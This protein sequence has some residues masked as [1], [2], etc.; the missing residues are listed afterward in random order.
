M[1]YSFLDISFKFQL[2]LIKYNIKR[3]NIWIRKYLGSYEVKWFKVLYLQNKVYTV[4]EVYK[5]ILGGL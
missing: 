2:Y 1:L 4:E 5:E 3:C